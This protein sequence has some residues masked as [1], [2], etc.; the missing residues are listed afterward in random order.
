M[1]YIY[2]FYYWSSLL[3]ATTR[4]GVTRREENKQNMKKMKDER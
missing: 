1:W 3:A 2:I 4:L